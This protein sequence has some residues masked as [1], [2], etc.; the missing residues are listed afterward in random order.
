M[1]VKGTKGREARLNKTPH[2]SLVIGSDKAS[3]LPGQDQSRIGP[4]DH[5]GWQRQYFGSIAKIGKSQ[6]RIVAI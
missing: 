6:P 3:S 2:L 1:Q 4:G 5:L